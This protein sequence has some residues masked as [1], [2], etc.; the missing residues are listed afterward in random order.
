MKTVFIYDLSDPLTGFVRYV[1]KSVRPKERLA[2]HI[3]QAR[4][5][6]PVYCKRWI[7]G[8][9][10]AGQRPV[11]SILEEVSASEADV[12]ERYW[13]ASLRLAG[14]ELTNLTPGGEGQAVGFVP[15]AHARAV[16][17]ART[18]GKP[19]PADHRASL[20]RAFNTPEA[21]ARRRQITT[22]RMADPVQRAIAATGRTGQPM[23]EEAK[24]KIA[25]SWT[26]ERK[27]QHAAEKS[28]LPVDERWRE[29]L[30]IALAARWAKYREAKNAG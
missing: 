10:Q 14:A 25:A 3:R 26:P 18:K 29:Q 23:S 4:A 15:S 22:A 12:A 5:G 17:S 20:Q 27:A 6:S 24:R 2:A 1:G 28:A 9:L 19:L 16:T 30:R 11:L 7:S 8:L 13:I 21:R